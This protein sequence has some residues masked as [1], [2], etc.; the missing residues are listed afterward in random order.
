MK[1]DAL[2]TDMVAISD[3]I[4]DEVVAMIVTRL[5]EAGYTRDVLTVP[6][7]ASV[8]L[9]VVQRIAVAGNVDAPGMKARIGWLAM[10][11]IQKDLLS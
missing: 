9:N 11:R 5:K 3:E 6:I 7:I 2:T 1:F 4:T 8:G 10:K